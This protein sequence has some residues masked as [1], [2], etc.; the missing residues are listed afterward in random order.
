MLFAL[1]DAGWIGVAATQP[2]YRGRGVQGAVFAAR[3][4]RA[5]EI[6]LRTLITETGIT[7]PPGPSYRNMLR[8]GFRPT[9]AR[10]VYAL[11]G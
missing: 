5:R 8:T 4:D 10:P 3:F 11:P 1:D 2:E 7:D 6:G 9:Y